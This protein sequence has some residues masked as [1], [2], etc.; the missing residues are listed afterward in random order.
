MKHI[1]RINFNPQ[2]L[3]A[4]F[5]KHL[6]HS[7]D[8][9]FQATVKL[10]FITVLIGSVIFTSC[11]AGFFL[12]NNRQLSLMDDLRKVW[13]ASQDQLTND[14]TRQQSEPI[15]LMLEANSDFKAW[16]TLGAGA[17]S[18]PVLQCDNN[19]FY[20]THNYKKQSSRYGALFFD[21]SNDA[22]G[23]SND[24][25]LIIYGNNMTDG[26][27]FGKLE[28]YRQIDYFKRNSTAVIDF[29]DC[30]V[31]Y[32]LFAVILFNP[33]EDF[34]LFTKGLADYEVLKLWS[35]EVKKRSY[36]SCEI[37]ISEGDSFLTLVTDSDE[38]EGAKTVVIARK[39]R[40]DETTYVDLE[41]FSVN[42]NPRLPKKI[43]EE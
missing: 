27:L 20:K 15:R 32:K 28:N 5:K 11:Y 31:A 10:S 39:I 34:G 3:K 42:P 17:I 36:I 9:I 4:F 37:D 24:R 6:P 38:F 8:N 12:Q 2:K 23:D 14:K 25:N 29:T 21:K 41:S 35:D 26:S 16:L 7:K 1:K 19:T 22:L 13:Q 18:Y 40:S 30:T 43:T 33:K